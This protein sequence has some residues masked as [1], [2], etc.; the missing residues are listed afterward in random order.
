MGC[1]GCYQ[2]SEFLGK[3][4]LR[5]VG[6][7]T[8]FPNAKNRILGE[9]ILG[10]S[11][12]RDFRKDYFD[13]QGLKVSELLKAEKNSIDLRGMP[14]AKVYTYIPNSKPLP[15]IQS[16]NCRGHANGNRWGLDSPSG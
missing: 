9:D 10:L 15:E 3:S 1:F 16:G 6:A 11:K 7:I 8:I 2:G 12:K 14:F 13:A 5:K 4:N